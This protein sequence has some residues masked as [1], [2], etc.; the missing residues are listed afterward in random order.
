MQVYMHRN[1][2]I[3]AMTF[4]AVHYN[5]EFKLTQ[6]KLTARCTILTLAAHSQFLVVCKE[7]FVEC[8]HWMAL[9][10]AFNRRLNLLFSV[11]VTWPLGSSLF[12]Y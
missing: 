10:E 5:L 11:Y 6:T 4:C 12:F 8:L 7:A 1:S 2:G 9:L 3:A